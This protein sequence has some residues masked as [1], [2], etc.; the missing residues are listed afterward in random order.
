MNRNMIMIK[1]Q[2]EWTHTNR[3]IRTIWYDWLLGLVGITLL[4]FG[5]QSIYAAFQEK[6]PQAALMF[7]LLPAFPALII[8]VVVF[9]QVFRRYRKSVSVNKSLTGPNE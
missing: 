5:F 3:N 1:L 9:M 7:V 4:L 6:M 8:L 2:K